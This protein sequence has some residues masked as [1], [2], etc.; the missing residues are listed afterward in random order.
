MTREIS[1]TAPV[2]ELDKRKLKFISG[3][4]TFIIVPYIGYTLSTYKNDIIK[5]NNFTPSIQK[6][7]KG[8][9]SKF[10]T[11]VSIAILPN[12]KILMAN[13]SNIFLF[14][15]NSEELS[16]LKVNM[17][18]RIYAPTAVAVHG[19][20][21]FIANYTG[22]NILE[23]KLD[24][25]LK[26]L[27]IVNDITSSTTIS[28]EGVAIASDKLIGVANYDSNNVQFFKKDNHKWNMNCEINVPLAHGIVSHD[29]YFFAS[30]LETRKI[31]KIDPVACKVI[32]ERGGQGW[33][34]GE[35]L[36]PTSLSVTS[37][38][39][40]IVSDAHTGKL[41]TLSP[42]N[43]Q[44]VH[45]FGGNGP[46]IHG[47][48][49]PYGVSAGDF[50]WVTSTFGNRLVKYDT[51]G[52]G[53]EVWS[54]SKEQQ[55]SFYAPESSF[56]NNQNYKKY[57]SSIN[58]TINGSCYRPSYGGLKRCWFGKDISLQRVAGNYFYFVQATPIADGVL[59]SSPQ[60]A[61]ALFYKG[62]KPPIEVNIGYDTWLVN[63]KLVNASGEVKLP[64]HI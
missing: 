39:L 27:T 58:I 30:S 7:F 37:T 35:F 53:L 56:L 22:N 26:L 44:P 40:I 29:G 33:K 13:Y 21:I 31:M 9:T 2:L 36:W 3:L 61:Q 4:L 49:M 52:R 6:V 25:K 10:T 20:K 24:E 5:P 57:L 51:V 32:L 17:K 11:P 15:Q 19:D 43:L 12:G 16:I 45:S 60:N 63:G 55:W 47:L 62:D 59:I 34:Q 42:D 23:V 28:P 8:D 18:G 64:K 14:D 46:G 54:T 41:T 48:N 38:G 50:I 1:H